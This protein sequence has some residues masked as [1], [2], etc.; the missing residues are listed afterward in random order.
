MIDEPRFEIKDHRSRPLHV[1]VRTY[2]N[3]LVSVCVHVRVSP[4]FSPLGF[5]Y[6]LYF[7]FGSI[8]EWREKF[9]REQKD[10]TFSLNY[11]KVHARVGS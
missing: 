7:K 1:H 3:V 6:L 5:I 10:Q 8:L 4:T 2:A 9:E 11:R